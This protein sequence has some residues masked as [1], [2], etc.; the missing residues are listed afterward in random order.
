MI[1]RL[2]DRINELISQKQSAQFRLNQ[3]IADIHAIDGAIQEIQYW[4]AILEGEKDDANE[5]KT[6]SDS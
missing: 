3:A 6:E 2:Q 5:N 4:M 1:S